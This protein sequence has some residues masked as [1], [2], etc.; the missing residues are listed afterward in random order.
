M[1]ALGLGSSV[2]IWN[3]ETRGLVGHLDLSPQSGCRYRQSVSSLCWSTD[4][5]ALSIA[6][7]RGEIQVNELIEVGNL[8]KPNVVWGALWEGKCHIY[9]ISRMTVCG[10]FVSLWLFSCGMSNT[11]RTWGFCCHT[12]LW[13]ERFLG[14]S[15]YL[16]GTHLFCSGI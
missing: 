7:R 16:A 2:Y 10:V 13:W 5:R 14:N 8:F 6:T 15:S 3:S 11:S 1:V 12:W 4:G 9:W